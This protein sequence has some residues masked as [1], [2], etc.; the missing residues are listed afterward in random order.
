VSERQT[1]DVIGHGVRNDDASRYIPRVSGAANIDYPSTDFAT[2]G[3]KLKLK[4]LSE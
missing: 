2:N 4:D 3:K 1:T